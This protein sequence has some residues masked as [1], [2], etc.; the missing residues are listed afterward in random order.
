[1][2]NDMEVGYYFLHERNYRAAKSRLKEALDFDP[3]S[4]GALIVLAQ[5]E[6]KVGEKLVRKTMHE[7]TVRNTWS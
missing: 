1:M 7:N 6:Q 2:P 5:A 3:T 4:S